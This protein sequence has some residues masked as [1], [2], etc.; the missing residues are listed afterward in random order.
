MP[1]P[2]ILTQSS[3]LH[4][5]EDNQQKK[6]KT[7]RRAEDDEGWR[8]DLRLFGHPP[9]T[10]VMVRLARRGKMNKIVPCLWLQ[11]RA[12]EAVSFWLQA[13]ENGHE[14]MRNY[15]PDDRH[16][17]RGTVMT[18]DFSLWDCELL[19]LNGDAKMPFSPAQFLRVDCSSRERL[20]RLWA[21]LSEGGSELMALDSYPFSDCFGWLADPFGLN[22]QLRLADR[23]EIAPGMMFCDALYG[24]GNEAIAAWGNALAP[25]EREEAILNPD[26]TLQQSRFLLCGQ[27]FLLQENDHSHDFVLSSAFSLCV[28]CDSQNEIDRLW[29]ILGEGGQEIACGWLRDAFG[30]CWQILPRE[31]PML[32]DGRQQHKAYQVMQAL[33]PMKKIDLQ[34]L[35]DAWLNA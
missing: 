16:L 2:Q 21:A 24:R 4:Q 35:H 29:R 25:C 18:V 22:W 3:I 15:Y 27:P 31:L 20:E 23:D 10:I 9:C 7:P 26:G 30:Q 33:Y 5:R 34:Q 8:I 32:L 13:F 1:D 17:P 14:R 6:L 12:Q 28:W 19:A 11:E